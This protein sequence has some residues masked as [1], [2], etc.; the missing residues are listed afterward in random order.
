MLLRVEGRLKLNKGIIY[1]LFGKMG[2]T[3][4]ELD[5]NGGCM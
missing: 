4:R 1:L 5:I 3:G 2:R